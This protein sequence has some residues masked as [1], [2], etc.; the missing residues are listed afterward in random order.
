MYRE[1]TEI[2]LDSLSVKKTVDSFLSPDWHTTVQNYI[3]SST[4]KLPQ[5]TRKHLD[6]L[7]IKVYWLVFSEKVTFNFFLTWSSR[8]WSSLSPGRL[9]G[10]RTCTGLCRRGC[11]RGELSGTSASHH[12][13]HLRPQHWQCRGW[14]KFAILSSLGRLRWR[15]CWLGC[16]CSRGTY[17]T[18]PPYWTVHRAHLGQV[19]HKW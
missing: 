3:L 17:S 6:L 1:A 14:G 2:I 9:G 4:T 15:W 19:V 16:L 8:C 10:G 5:T 13:P 12:A 7:A 11:W 18:P